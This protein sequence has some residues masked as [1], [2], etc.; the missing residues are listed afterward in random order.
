[1]KK[2]ILLLLLFFTIKLTAQERTMYVVAKTG[3]NIRE[4]PEVN[5]K[6]LDKIP[7]A[8]KI[9]WQESGENAKKIITEGLTGYWR[10]VTYNDKTGYIIDSY[11]FPAVPPAAGTKTL[12]DYLAQISV[13]FGDNLVVTKGAMENVEEGGSQLSKQLYKNGAEWHEFQGYE[14]N[15][16][17]YFVPGVTMQQAFL[18]VRLIPEFAEY[19]SEKDEYITANKKLKKKDRDYE[20][21]VEKET[22]GDTPWINKITIGFEDGAI[23]KFEMFQTDAQV[24]IF[25]GS[26]L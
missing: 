5:A 23:Y 15:S 2:M 22:F 26:G 17:M 18:L 25:Y 3:L 9:V 4:K 20:Y 14:Y 7:Y 21:K 19:I 12:K 11:L 24:V 13:L 6:V 8:T 16:M 10:K 1:M